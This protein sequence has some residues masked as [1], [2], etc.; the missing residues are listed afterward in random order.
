MYYKLTIHETARNTLKEDASLFNIE[1]QKRESLEAIRQVLLDRYGTMPKA[2]KHNLIYIADGEPIGFMH[3][4]W[5]RDISHGGP[6]WY[7]TDWIEITRV[8]E[9]TVLLD[10]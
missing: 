2:N 9:E 7:Q 6:S 3:S 4:Y 1:E 10:N 8:H 5:N